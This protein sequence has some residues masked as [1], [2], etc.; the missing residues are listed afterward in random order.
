MNKDDIKVEVSNGYLLVAIK[1]PSCTCAACG[2][3]YTAD[4][5]PGRIAMYI[6]GCQPINVDPTPW[7]GAGWNFVQLS[8][9]HRFKRAL[10]CDTCYAPIAKL[11]AA[12]EDL[13]REAHAKVGAM[14]KVWP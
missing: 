10:V 6:H 8:E 3:V 14:V 1:I 12:A 7:C 4:V 13:K 5:Q 2:K 11:E 9:A